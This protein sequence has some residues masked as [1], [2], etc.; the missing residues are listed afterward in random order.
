MWSYSITGRLSSRPAERF[1]AARLARCQH[2]GSA[3]FRP[4]AAGSAIASVAAAWNRAPG[5]GSHFTAL[6]CFV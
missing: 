6:P 4:V 5:V 3:H 2:N 1:V